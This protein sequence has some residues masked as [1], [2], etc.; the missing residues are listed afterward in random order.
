[1][2]FSKGDLVE[3]RDCD[4]ETWERAIFIAFDDVTGSLYKYVC[5]HNPACCA[6]AFIYCR[7][8]RPDLKVDDPVWVMDSC[9]DGWHRR[10]FSGW[11]ESGKII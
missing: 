2:E 3:V 10:H 6:S 11:D 4:S 8:A 7:P 9:R 5:R 1:M